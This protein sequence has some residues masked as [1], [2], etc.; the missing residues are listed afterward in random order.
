[1]TIQLP[2][3]LHLDLIQVHSTPYASTN[4]DRNG[5]PKTALYGGSLRGRESSQHGRYHD[6]GTVEAILGTHAC[7]TRATTTQAAKNLAERGWHLD[8]ALAA[9][10]MLILATQIKGLGVTD[11][12]GTNVLLFLPAQAIT[13]LADLV[14]E[15]RDDFAP[16]LAAAHAELAKEEEKKKKAKAKTKNNDANAATDQAADESDGDVTEDTGRTAALTTQA[17]KIVDKKNGFL[18]KDAILSI[19]RTRNAIVAAYGR[20]LANEPGS[21]VEGAIQTAHTLSTHAITTQLDSF[22][23][24][25][26]II[27]TLGEEAGAGH[28]GEQRY[29]SA[30]WYRY[31]TLDIKRLIN[32]LDGDTT[33]TQDVIEAILRT[34]YTHRQ[35]GKVSGTAPHTLPHLVYVSVRTDRPV[36]LAGAYEQP[37]PATATGGY[38]TTSLERLDAHAGAH[39]RLLGTTRIAGHHHLSLADD[40]T[41]THLGDQADNLD[42]LVATT[43]DTI[44]KALA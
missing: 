25:D 3:G 42:Q 30:T 2:Q 14:H 43:L 44:R 31:S 23:A 27:K 9:V 1:M 20:M 29:N 15:H 4:R 40:L 34:P 33:T 39:H 41:F 17:K 7:R 35:V 18:T 8:D 16:Y 37:V 5:S 32:N 10:Q 38:L 24:V 36:N 6:R 12:G 22:T 13:E 11:N 19:L 26:D 21:T 28:M